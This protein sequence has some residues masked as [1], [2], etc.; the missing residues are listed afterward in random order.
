MNA[1]HLATTSIVVLVAATPALAAGNGELD[2]RGDALTFAVKVTGYTGTKD[3]KT[4]IYCIP[5]KTDLRGM[6]KLEGAD[7]L[8]VLVPTGVG[9]FGNPPGVKDCDKATPLPNDELIT[10]SDVSKDNILDYGGS[11]YGL[12]YGGLVVPFK[13]H[14][15]GAK[16]FA[17]GGTVAP[18]LGYRFDKNGLAFGVKAVV[19][20]GAAGVS[21]DQVVDGEKKTQTLA[22]LSYGLGLLGTVKGNFQFGLVLG[23]DRVSKSANYAHNGKWWTSLAIGFD[24]AE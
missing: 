13:Y 3:A 14:L 12:T 22:G 18:Y 7:T 19:F 23:A 9:P 5:A 21:V 6:S 1:L 16:E 10:L 15:D 20:L 24:F 2:Y 8:K 11:R 4:K 17:T